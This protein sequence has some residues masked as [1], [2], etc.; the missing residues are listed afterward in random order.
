MTVKIVLSGTHCS[1]KTTTIRRLQKRLDDLGVDAAC[2]FEIIRNCPYT[3]NE[4]GSEQTEVWAIS[5][6]ILAELNIKAKVALLDR[7]IFDNVSYAEWTRQRGNLSKEAFEFISS[8]AF[9]WARLNPYVLIF[10]LDPLPLVEDGMRSTNQKFQQEIHDIMSKLFVQV[11]NQ[12]LQTR[13]IWTGKLDDAKIDQM[14][15][16]ILTAIKSAKP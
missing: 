16:E 10:V 9:S 13:I 5:K 12:N 3:I 11:Q 7:C 14:L 2:V 4:G 1:G 6:Q 8:V 15:K